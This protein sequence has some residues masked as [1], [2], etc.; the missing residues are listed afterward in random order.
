MHHVRQR[1]IQLAV[2]QNYIQCS[3]WQTFINLRFFYWMDT[4]HTLLNCRVGKVSLYHIASPT[5]THVPR[6]LTSWRF[7][8]RALHSF[9][10]SRVYVLYEKVHSMIARKELYPSEVLRGMAPV[11]KVMVMKTGKGAFLLEMAEKKTHLASVTEV[12]T[13]HIL[14]WSRPTLHPSQ[15]VGLLT[16]MVSLRSWPFMNMSGASRLST[17]SQKPPTSEFNISRNVVQDT[18]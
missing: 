11:Q 15:A 3:F 12:A 4:P 13:N 7:R 17:E 16:T 5:G 1:L 14:Q 6:A 2:F 10:L 9:L 8:V 18:S